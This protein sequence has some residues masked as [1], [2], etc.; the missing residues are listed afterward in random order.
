MSHDIEDD[1]NID[2]AEQNWD[3]G[4]EFGHNSNLYSLVKAL[5]EEADRFDG[6]MEEVYH[7]QHINDAT[8]EDLEKF[9]QLVQTPRKTGESDPKYR[10]RI[11]AAF[12]V[13]NI[14]TTTDQFIEFGATILNTNSQNI[15]LAYP[16]LRADN[17]AQVNFFADPSIYGSVNLTDQEVADIL[18]DAVPAGHEVVVFERGTFRLKTDGETGDPDKGLT[19][20]S[21]S[22]GGTLAADLL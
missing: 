7:S 16:N 15:E 18:D 20:D 4:L 10:A 3:S 8:G 12:R 11:K 5:L 1:R 9:G 2:T 21:I 19:S 6:S 13:G 17:P 22:T 14:G